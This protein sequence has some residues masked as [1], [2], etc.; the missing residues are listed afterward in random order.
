MLADNKLCTGC[1]ACYNICPQK[2]ISMVEDN[3]GFLFP[4]IN[5]KLCIN[6]NRCEKV[7]PIISR[8]VL[9]QEVNTVVIQNLDSGLREKSSAGGFIAALL[10]YVF[11][12]NGVAYGACFDEQNQVIHKRVINMQECIDSNLFG[13]K[14]VSSDLGDSFSQ[15]LND[16]KSNKVVCFIGLP[17]Q[18]A[19]LS[20]FLGREYDNLILVDLTCYGVPSPKLYKKYLSMCE[21]KYNAKVLSVNFRDKTFGYSA[22]SMSILFNDGHT[23]GQNP[24]IKSYLRCFFSNISCRESCYNCVFKTVKRISDFTLGDCKNIKDFYVD[25][26]DDLGT[27][28][29]YIQTE[30]AKLILSNKL[31]CIK[32]KEVPIN[33][34][35]DTCGQKMIKTMNIN[36]QRERFFKDIDKLDYNN[37]INRYCKPSFSEDIAS[38]VKNILLKLKLNKCGL[39]KK[40]K[41]F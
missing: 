39:I 22:P 4:K 8:H 32:Y 15:V 29:V 40:I 9:E 38:L 23:R 34:I 41:G 28:V 6:C 21:R 19:G 10:K 36:Q 13:S 1:G 18:V 2:C 17:C 37:L 33:Q 11:S 31:D 3:G 12:V 7:C 26:D 35:L 16:L 14:Y 30:K 20:N 27:T 25:M 24:Y 5:E